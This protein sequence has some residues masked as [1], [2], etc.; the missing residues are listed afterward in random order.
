[1]RRCCRC[2][3]G[4]AMCCASASRI[5][6]SSI[7]YYPRRHC[8]RTR[9]QPAKG[10]QRTRKPSSSVQRSPREGWKRNGPR[11]PRREGPSWLPRNEGREGAAAGRRCPV[12]GGPVCISIRQ[13]ALVSFFRGLRTPHLGYFWEMRGRRCAGWANG[14]NGSS[15]V[16]AGSVIK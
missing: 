16:L 6:C 12:Y 3:C 4:G 11:R 7:V 8:T 9:L 2:C 10:R 14:R 5:L 13:T 1:M 15:G